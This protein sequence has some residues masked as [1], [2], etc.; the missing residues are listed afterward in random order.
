MEQNIIS[1][2]E[3]KT[4]D[5]AEN[6]EKKP[7]VRRGSFRMGYGNE[8]K[9]ILLCIAGAV[10]CLC[11]MIVGLVIFGAPQDFIG[12]MA[13]IF[14]IIPAVLCVIFIPI[15]IY[16]RN[17]SYYA[18][19]EEFEAITP[20]G[21]EYLYYS[22]VSEVIYKPIYLF[23]KQRGWYVTVVTGVRDFTFRC[24]FD[25]SGEHTE[26]KHTPFYLLELNSGLKKPEA[27][28]PE[29]AAAIMSQFAVMQEK[30]QDRLSKKRKRRS[31]KNLFDE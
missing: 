4:A 8:G 29:L 17:C 27:D 22:D 13:S 1:Q 30:Q 21:S 5:R 9:L 18:G 20:R 15:V 25:N 24:L 10:L 2:T 12:F 16:G 28:D 31:L 7:F 23:K 14:W 19:V 11:M 6:D 26:P 3:N